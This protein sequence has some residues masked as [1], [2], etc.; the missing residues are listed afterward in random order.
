MNRSSEFLVFW[1]ATGLVLMGLSA[2]G[3]GTATQTS[4]SE[5]SED[6]VVLDKPSLG[7]SARMLAGTSNNV[8]VTITPSSSNSSNG[9]TYCVRTNRLEPAA[10]DAC[11][12]AETRQ[13]AST[14][15]S[16]TQAT[17]VV[18]WSKSSAGLVTLAGILAVPGKT[19]SQAAYDASTASA[20]PTVCVVTDKGELVLA[21]EN[22]KAPQ[23]VANFLRYVNEGFYNGTYFHRVSSSFVVQGGGFVFD[24]TQYN[25]KNATYDPIRLEKTTETT[26]SN[27]Q[28]SVAMARTGIENS[29]TTEFFINTVNNASS[30]NATS[31]SGGYAVFGQ[32]IFGQTTTLNDI[33][34]VSV[35]SSTILSGENS[36]PVTPL[37][38][39]WAYQIQ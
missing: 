15:G 33:K 30:L 34:G 8:Q 16:A 18:I 32:T 39:Q 29:A 3:G 38:L 17:P 4:T 21:L 24:G 23:S 6:D 14:L 20:L 10:G 2:C 7:L 9:A 13:T 19:C 26:L 31:S 1:A 37:A 35:T 5:Q 25:K 11:F 12:K 28:Y 22:V 27:I 36:Q